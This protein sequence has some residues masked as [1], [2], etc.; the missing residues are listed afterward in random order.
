MTLSEL[1]KQVLELDA[2]ATKGPWVNSVVSDYAGSN[3][4]DPNV[5]CW[6]NCRFNRSAPI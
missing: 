5:Q 3:I 1:C 6:G 2:K 4:Y